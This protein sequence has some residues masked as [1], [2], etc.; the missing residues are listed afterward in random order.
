MREL[1]RIKAKLD[2]HVS[3][4]VNKQ[5]LCLLDSMKKLSY[6]EFIK[7]CS[8]LSTTGGCPYAVKTYPGFKPPQPFSLAKLKE[9]AKELNV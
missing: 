7:Y 5:I 4:L 3:V 6:E 8:Y 2:L 1:S 9:Y